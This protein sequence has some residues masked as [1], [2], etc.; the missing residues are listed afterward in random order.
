MFVDIPPELWRPS[1]KMGKVETVF[2]FSRL[3]LYVSSNR[4][5]ADTVSIWQTAV[6]F[7]VDLK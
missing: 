3:A 6:D 4:L 5:Y 7:V 2:T 1:I